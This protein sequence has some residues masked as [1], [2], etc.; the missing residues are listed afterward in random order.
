MLQ[1]CQGYQRTLLW[2]LGVTDVDAGSDIKYMV[3]MQTNAGY[4]R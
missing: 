3:E 4:Q 1:H 2:H